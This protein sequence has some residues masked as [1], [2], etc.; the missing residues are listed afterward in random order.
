MLK[1]LTL[2]EAIKHEGKV[3]IEF[4]NFKELNGWEAGVNDALYTVQR[5]IRHYGL[6]RMEFGVDWRL[7]VGQPTDEERKMALWEK[8]DEHCRKGRM[9]QRGMQQG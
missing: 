5:C 1:P 8:P 6:H 2:D 9:E 3:Y 4:R 7:W